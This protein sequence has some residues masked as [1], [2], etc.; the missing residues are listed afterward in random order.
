[1]PRPR[2]K[3]LA[4]QVGARIAE[5]RIEIGLTQ[6]KAAYEVGLTKQYLGQ[7]E[8]GKRLPS[9]GVMKLIADRFDVQLADLVALDM[10]APR[11]ALL[12]ATRRKDASGVRAALRRL[13]LA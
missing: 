13:G 2:S 3:K 6:E 9:L 1:M 12:E 11:L 4:E 7:I 10:R 8:A 5:L